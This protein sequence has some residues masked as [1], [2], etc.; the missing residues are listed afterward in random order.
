MFPCKMVKEHESLS[1]NNWQDYSK[2]AVKHQP[3]SD[4]LILNFTD[5]QLNTVYKSMYYYYYFI[6]D[7][8]LLH[9]DIVYLLHYYYVHYNVTVIIR[10][11]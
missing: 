9:V 2:A 5:H 6:Q 4:Q 1:N 11:W 3:D 8:L 10:C 7:L